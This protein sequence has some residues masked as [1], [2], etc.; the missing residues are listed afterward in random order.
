M[1]IR[2]IIIAL[3]FSASLFQAAAQQKYT[4]LECIDIALE[5]NRNIKQQEIGRQ[6]REI[7]YSQA[8]ADLL[9]NLN[10]SAGQNFV[11]GRSIGLDNVYENTNSSQTSFS[12]G[13][14]ITLFDGLRMKHNIDARK[15]DMQASEADLEKMRDDVVMSVSTAFLQALLNRELLQIAENQIETTQAN[16]QRRSELVKSGKMAQGELYE[17]EAQLAKE[18]LNRVQAE[19]NLKLAL[20]DLAQIMELEEFNNFDITAPP[21][22]TL[23]NEATLLQSEAVYESALVNRPEIRGMRYRL[24]SSEKELLMAKAQ[25]Y[26]S[27]SFGV[28]MGTG[29][30]R[31]SGRDNTSFSSQLRNNMSN[32]LGFSLRIPIFNRFQIRNSVHSAELAI[33]NTQ[34]E[35]DKTKVELRKRIEQAYYNAT[36]AKSRWDA[37]RKSIEASRESYRFAEEKY[38]SGRANSYELFLAKNNLT[39]VLGEEAQAKY[40]YAFR[41]KILE[42]LKD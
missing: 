33:A 4:L 24:E 7:A 27:L 6:Q 29:Y 37:A 34:L 21:A 12:I 14:D 18:E 3:F 38:E 2:T 31:M 19:S 28:N 8:R 15:A 40:E 9:P 42:L 26:P 10:A 39:Q 41:L 17:L 1:H 32:S 36:G 11:F 13:G 22:E 25:Y 16:L 35:M 20:L 5:N 30:Y 23:I